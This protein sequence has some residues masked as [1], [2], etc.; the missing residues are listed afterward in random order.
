[1]VAQLE[2]ELPQLE[3]FSSL[4]PVPNFCK[5]LYSEDAERVELDIKESHLAVLERTRSQLTEKGSSCSSLEKILD[6]LE[7]HPQWYRDAELNQALELPLMHLMTQYLMS[8]RHN[9]QLPLCPV[10]SF[11]LQNGAVLRRINWNADLSRKGLDNSAGMMVNYQYILKDL[12]ANMAQVAEGSL[13]HALTPF[14]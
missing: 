13:S 1:M 12:D 10:A 9:R 2:Q 3:L 11:H 14:A 5:W 7:G 4:S 8:I 6:V